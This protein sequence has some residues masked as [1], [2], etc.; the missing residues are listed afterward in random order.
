ME[1]K[2]A[3][4]VYTFYSDKNNHV[5]ICCPACGFKRTVDASNYKNTSKA[6]N[7]KCRCGELFQ[8]LID[9]RKFYRKRVNLIGEFITLK[10]N[11]KGDMLVEDLSIGG[12]GFNNRSPHALETG[13]VLELRFT[14]DNAIQ[15]KIIRKVKVMI[16]KG[17]FI[18]TEFTEKN[19]LDPDLGFY[20]LP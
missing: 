3:E 7:V 6:L 20:L 13:D 19:L 5:V 14:L 12:V 2:Q 11:K 17:Y 4:T 8:C 10:N 16:I 18:G 1:L 9:S 15:T